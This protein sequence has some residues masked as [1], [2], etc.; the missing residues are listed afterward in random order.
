MKRDVS[1]RD[2]SRYYRYHREVGHDTLECHDLK[3]QIEQLIRDGKL[4][5]YKVKKPKKAG[6]KH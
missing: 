2:Q 4:R 1:K 6:S 3:D 5:E